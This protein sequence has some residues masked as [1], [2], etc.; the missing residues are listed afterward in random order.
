M[1]YLYLL[2]KH[3]ITERTY[4]KLSSGNYFHF[5]YLASILY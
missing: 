2:K 5:I 4:N 1:Y 3:K